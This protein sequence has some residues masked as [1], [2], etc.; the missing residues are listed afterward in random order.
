MK[1][2]KAKISVN[3]IL[4]QNKPVAFILEKIFFVFFSLT[5][6]LI[7]T[8]KSENDNDNVTVISLHR[9]GDTI[10]TLPA[11][12]EIQK[13][14]RR[15]IN[16]VCFPESEYIYNFALSDVRFCLLR[17]DDFSWNGRLAGHSA[18]SKLKEL[19]SD[20]IFD[21]TGSLVSASLIFNSSANTIVG[22]NGNLF[23][24]IYTK[25]VE[26][27]QTPQLKEIYLDAISPLVSPA[28]TKISRQFKNS[29]PNGKIVIHPFAGW[30]EKEWNLKKYISL[31]EKLKK[32][33]PV[34]FIIMGDELP[35]DVKE[36]I[37]YSGIE[38][39]E[40]ESVDHLIRVINA[41]SI[42][43]GNDSGP[44][45]IANYLGKPT[46]TIFG[47]TNPEYTSTGNEYQ[48]FIIKNLSCSA[49]NN[50]KVCLIGGAVYKCSGTQC[51][52]LLTVEDVFDKIS[53]LISSYLN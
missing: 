22:I 11:I 4:N 9:L 38:I 30:K 25:F 39:I 50:E 43:I 44:V 27:R 10:F 1:I 2:N 53:I 17:K 45:N 21:L 29:N 33:H 12:I 7:K 16:I 46:F 5:R 6:F 14:Y 18:R 52:N 48:Q 36:E 41:C 20:I 42:F 35:I 19:H 24:S 51:M 49:G 23:K 15:M 34:S 37:K 32:L 47:S 31:A 40:S 3:E 28:E 26:F 8:S 13:H